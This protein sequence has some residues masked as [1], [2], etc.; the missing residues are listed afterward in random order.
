MKM[1]Q[2]LKLKIKLKSPKRSDSGVYSFAIRKNNG[3]E[4]IKIFNITFQCK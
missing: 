3:T 2:K 4:I 1:Q